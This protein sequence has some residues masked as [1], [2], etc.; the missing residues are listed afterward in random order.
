[1]LPS[2]AAPG[3]APPP[4]RAAAGAKLPPPDKSETAV[5]TGSTGGGVSRERPPAATAAPRL[6]PTGVGSPGP[7]AQQPQGSMA[8]RALA[9][10][11]GLRTRGPDSRRL[12]EA[13]R[14][15]QPPRPPGTAPAPPQPRTL[16][17]APPLSPAVPGGAGRRL[18]VP[19]TIASGPRRSDEK[20]AARRAPPLRVTPGAANGGAALPLPREGRALAANQRGRPPC[21]HVS[22][23]GG[24][25]GVA[26]CRLFPDGAA[27]RRGAALGRGPCGG[28]G[29]GCRERPC[30]K[31]G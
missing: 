29:G 6:S 16:G 8:P 18:P 21:R 15:R 4:G 11:P 17:P 19:A 5:G 30:G 26:P 10:S 1:M 23:S 13:P 20:P 25:E 24:A 3:S 31:P 7:A 27:S 22:R 12:P 2:P 14:R 9:P 28:G